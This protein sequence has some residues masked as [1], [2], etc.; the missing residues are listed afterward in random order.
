[1]EC[2]EEYVRQRELVED[3]R[4]R[5]IH[6]YEKLVLVEGIDCSSSSSE[7]ISVDRLYVNLSIL[8]YHEAKRIMDQQKE[9][10]LE[11]LDAA[12]KKGFADRHTEARQ[13]DLES[14]LENQGGLR[15]NTSLVI[16]NGGSGKTVT[17]AKIISD[18]MSRRAFLRFKLVVHVSGRDAEL[19]GA[20]NVR[21]LL[22][23]EAL[24]YSKAEQTD[25]LNYV[26]RN[27]REVLYIIDGA[28]EVK[29]SGI[30]AAGKA[31]A[32]LL[33]PGSR[34]LSS[35]IILTRPC[36]ESHNL[37]H[38]CKTHFCLIGLN[39]Q[40]LRNLV[41]MRL[42]DPRGSEFM[43]H[44]EDVS[45]AHIKALIQDTP[46]FASMTTQ[47]YEVEGGV[48]PETITD[49]FESMLRHLFERYQVKTL[50]HGET[51][52]AELSAFAGLE[53]LAFQGMVEEKF[54]FNEKRVREFCPQHCLRLALL[55]EVKRGCRTFT[56]YHLF[57][58]EFLAARCI[59]TE[60]NIPE[61][62]EKCVGAVGVGGHTWQFWKFVAAFLPQCHVPEL[63]FQLTS[64]AMSQKDFVPESTRFTCFLS[65]CLAESLT[66]NKHSQMT[67]FSEMAAE[68]I[69]P[70]NMPFVND[71]C[72][73]T[74]EAKAVGIAISAAKSK[75][76][77]QVCKCSLTEKSWQKL[78][79]C[80]GRL[81]RLLIDSSGAIDETVMQHITEALSESATL[82]IYMSPLE[83]SAAEILWKA[84]ITKNFSKLVLVDCELDSPHLL[85]MLN[86]APNLNSFGL[87][88]LHVRKAQFGSTGCGQLLMALIKDMPN[89]ERLTL[90]ECNLND[91]DLLHLLDGMATLQRLILFNASGNHLTSSAVGIV[92]SFAHAR[93]QMRR[94]SHVTQ[95]RLRIDVS[96]NTAI[97]LEDV[98][99]ASQ[100]FPF[101]SGVDFQYADVV[102]NGHST[103]YVD[104][105]STLARHQSADG[106]VDMEH[107]GGDVIASKVAA[108]LETDHE[109]FYL[110]MLRSFVGNR[111]M[112]AMSAMLLLNQTLRGLSFTQNRITEDGLK[113]LLSSLLHNQK[114]EIVNISDNPL[115]SYLGMN[116]V[117]LGSGSNLSTQK[118]L[119]ILCLSGTGMTNAALENWSCAIFFELSLVTLDLSHNLI[120][121]TGVEHILQYLGES[122]RL[123]KLSLS[124]NCITDRGANLLYQAMNETNRE[125]QSRG[126]STCTIL[127]GRNRVTER[128]FSSNRCDL[129]PDDCLCT[130][131]RRTSSLQSWT[132][133]DNHESRLARFVAD[134]CL[135][136]D[137]FKAMIGQLLV[138]RN[139]ETV[140]VWMGRLLKCLSNNNVQ[141]ERRRKNAAQSLIFWS[142]RQKVVG[143][144]NTA[145]KLLCHSL[146]ILDKTLMEISS[147]DDKL[148]AF[149]E[150]TMSSLLAIAARVPA[151]PQYFAEFCQDAINQGQP[152]VARR[153]LEQSSFVCDRNS[154]EN[155]LQW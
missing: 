126:R 136:T 49:L 23:L 143:D 52:V 44:L 91:D 22:G 81:P 73:S 56:F 15:V 122:K 4:E 67:Q 102:V 147:S 144:F 134:A 46:L 87:T 150:I 7:P 135:Q 13:L 109:C 2:S 69:W 90:V 84:V 35:F 57:W 9:I 63:L 79:S 54:T 99:Q 47:L 10:T 14:L 37:I 75:D 128:F 89:L 130:S 68:L 39:D 106:E 105:A 51:P 120:S 30:L 141:S 59:R 42:G 19:V 97:S 98:L 31:I 110:D 53:K 34:T 60:H 25:I 148:N 95:E 82:D 132:E 1:M 125:T 117:N 85:Q 74:A 24:G 104:V 43:H 41:T 45:M 108:C 94:E 18:W 86:S 103:L 6:S 80:P 93:Y 88:T 131:N 33:Q 70:G 112:E 5:L 8:N 111:G 96:S 154:V 113:V 28:D 83:G 145:A 55:S 78:F 149:L 142:E 61:S 121:D 100:S 36:P 155:L 72:L 40:N 27:S 101:D 29:G 26:K 146:S 133:G 138:S 107:R 62:L 140:D 48:F 76:F 118:S 64:K 21:G 115:F 127:I 71:H 139:F 32:R 123:E 50:V 151:L 124:N 3:F 16:G 58:Q 12:S 20:K 119:K 92:V 11:K 66:F 129:L 65:A 153:L 152:A 137:S 17:C 77:L 114:L 38:V 116:K